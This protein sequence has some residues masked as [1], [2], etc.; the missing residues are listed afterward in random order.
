MSEGNGEGVGE[1]SGTSLEADV[2]QEL[3][4]DKVEEIATLLGTDSGAARE[5][6]GTT[7]STLPGEA[8]NAPP[9]QEA[10]LQGVATL[11]GMAG[12]GLMAGVLAKAAGPVAKAVAKKTGL[13]PVAVSRVVEILIPVLL[14]VLTKR[15]ARGTRK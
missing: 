2:L 14:T 8:G 10:P 1:G 15:A 11:G 7:V 9:A 4:D 3:G 12:G 6:V 13:S 5:M